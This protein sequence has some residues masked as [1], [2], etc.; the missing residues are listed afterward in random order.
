MGVAIGTN[1]RDGVDPLA[2][3]VAGEIGENREGRDNRQ[4][5]RGLRA[6]GAREGHGEGNQ[7]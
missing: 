1:K 4:F 6:D 5:G 3:D 7:N 2:S